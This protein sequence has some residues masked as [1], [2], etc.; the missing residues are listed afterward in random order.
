M[1]AKMKNQNSDVGR[2]VAVAAGVLT[3]PGPEDQLL[4]ALAHARPASRR[5]AAVLAA[6]YGEARKA[7]LAMDR[8]SILRNAVVDDEPS[9]TTFGELLMRHYAASEGGGAEADACKG[10]LEFL[11]VN[12]IRE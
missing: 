11:E 9:D 2:S 4:S 7:R 6:G 8:E 12:R 3:R 10:N 1:V 5:N